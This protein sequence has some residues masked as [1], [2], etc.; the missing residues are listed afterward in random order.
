MRKH[1]YNRG[2][3]VIELIVSTGIIVIVLGIVLA[4]YPKFRAR[5][6]LAAL[7]REVG[8][9][10]RESQVYGLAVKE[11]ENASGKEFPPYGMHIAMNKPKEF[12]LFG[13]LDGGTPN[14]YDS[15]DG[16]GTKTGITECIRRDSFSGPEYIEKI[17]VIP[18][19]GQ[20]GSGSG[21]EEICSNDKDVPE[22]NIT[23]RRPDPEAVIVI[24]DGNVRYNGAKIY[25]RSNRDSAE[26][27]EVRVWITGQISIM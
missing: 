22:L 11:F 7:A 17:C 23:F 26:T 3:T 16:C 14:K 27:K 15:G 18:G 13:D 20:G 2:F 21:L 1:N 24:S 5:S 9:L 25:L 10:V 12:I 4:G 6:S 19:G 8:L